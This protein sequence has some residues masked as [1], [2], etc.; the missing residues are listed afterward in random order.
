M[1]NGDTHDSLAQLVAAP[2]IRGRFEMRIAITVILFVFFMQVAM[3]RSVEPITEEIKQLLHRYC[4]DCHDASTLKGELNLE[5]FHSIADIEADSDVWEDVLQQIEHGEMPPKKK[6]QFSMEERKRFTSWIQQ[7]LDAIALSNAGDPGP[8]VLRRLNN[9]EYNYSIRDLTGVTSINPASEFPADNAAGEGFIN[10]GSAQS[11]SPVF[12]TKYLDAAKV[13]AT[14]AVLLPKGITF[15]EARSRREWTNERVAAIRHFYSKFTVTSDMQMEVGGRGQVPNEGGTIPLAKYLTAT[16]EERDALATDRTSIEDI[17]AERSLNEKYLRILWKALAQVPEQADNISS[18]MDQL[19]VQWRS[20]TPSE[21][22]KLT[23]WIKDHQQV[24]FQYNPIGHVGTDG[25][26]K[27]WMDT[28]LPLADRRD[29]SLGL[30]EKNNGDVSI[31]LTASDASDGNEGDF[32]VWEN[33]RLTI[34]NGPDILLRD[35]AGL[36]QSLKTAQTEI[37]ARTTDYLTAVEEIET[38]SENLTIKQLAN[39]AKQ[40][41]LEPNALKVWMGYLGIGP[42]EAVVISGHFNKTTIHGNYNFIHSWGTGTTPNVTANSSD[43]QVRIPGIAK[44]NGITAHPSPT[45]FV[46]IGWQSPIDGLVS[47]KAQLSDAHP[48][49]GDGQEWFL[50]HLSQRRAENLWKGRFGAGGSAKTIPKKVSVRKGELISLILGPGGNYTCDLTE[51]NLNISEALGEKRLWDLAKDVSKDL[52]AS[53]PHADR[54]GNPEVWHFYSGKM[55]SVDRNH[56]AIASV[57]S[58]SLLHRWQMESNTDKR[59]ELARQVQQLATGNPPR[60]PLSPDGILYAQLQNLSI[61]PHSMESL[62]TDATPDNRFGKHPMGIE[63]ASGNLIVKAPSIVEFKIPARLATGR[64]LVVGGVLDPHAGREGTVRLEASLSRIEPSAIEVTSPVVV[65]ENTKARARLLTTFADFRDL[66]PPQLCYGRIVPVD[67]VVTLTLFYRQDEALQR[68]MLNEEQTL[69]LNRLWDEL[70][71][72]AQEPLRYEV[73]FEQIREFA[74]QDRPDLVKVWDP[75]K[76]QVIAR[77]AAFRQRQV[78]TEPTHLAAIVEFAKRAWRRPLTEEEHAEFPVLYGSLRDQDMAHEDVIRHLLARVLVSPSFLYRGENSA[79]GSDPAP[80]TDWELATRLS[81]FLWSSIPDDALLASAAAG[82]LQNPNI[83]EAHLRR[84]LADPKVRRLA[85]EFGTQW[86]HV[87]DLSTLNEKSER[88]FPAFADLRVDM[89]EEAVLFF[90]DMFQRNR[91]ILSLLNAN[92]TFLNKPLAAHYGIE[93]ETEGW[94]RV[95]GLHERGRGGILGF[96][97]TLSKHSGASRTSPIL[98]GNW[99]YEVLLGE[100]LPKPPKNVPV[101]PDESPEGLT[102]RQLIQKHSSDPTCAR[103]HSKIDPFGFALEDFDAIGGARNGMNTLAILEDGSQFVGLEG[104]RSYLLNNRRDDF[105][106]QFC[107][108]LLGYALGRSVQLSDKQLLDEMQAA[109]KASDYRVQSA[110]KLIV[111]S[112]QFRNVRG[113]DSNN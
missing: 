92:Y 80:I 96:A 28:N 51:M 77:A 3:G 111:L 10:T 40:H 25:K 5:R 19:R 18:L 103:C 66:F 44:A 17:A 108:K 70:L 91:S 15:S 38:N 11:M 83:L 16:L 36:R 30:T 60:D 81:Y 97:S 27:V 41:G 31:F 78:D 39:V 24:L 74:T 109:L 7:T 65:N 45:D 47:I 99:V 88:H 85:T 42:N 61:S 9:E 82:E 23:T 86:L 67:E 93:I 89:Q 62:L 71:Y 52:L 37:L 49:C 105:V 26:P 46:A 90:V 8:V 69:E 104:L 102:E 43:N 48:E 20:T 94:R 54:Y 87:R 98:R 107:R 14:H 110:V 50:Q 33:P 100:K 76:P 2:H 64:T 112:P 6:P 29:I 72:V 4:L 57:P 13:V 79:L 21:V 1:V 53:N 32:V 95:D 68:L 106:R 101:L 84:M 12:L 34:D 75:L 55:D 73:A 58:G 22:N 113:R 56:G 63:V 59:I 35:L